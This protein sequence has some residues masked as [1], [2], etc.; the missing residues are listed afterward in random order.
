MGLMLDS[1]ILIA[2]EKGLLDLAGLLNSEAASEPVFISAVTASELLH[3]CE[4]A[5]AGEKRD[6]R[7]AFV[8]DVLDRIPAA[9]FG[10][11][12]A[13]THARLWAELE[14]AGQP[15]GAHDLIIAATCLHL[16]CRLATLNEKD[17]RRVPGLE[18]VDSRRYFVR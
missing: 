17:Y 15:I 14:K 6:R 3:G 12:Q 7:K 11:D 2:A 18:L 16:R 1:S 8:E 4:R 9:P 10:L 5:P 13:R